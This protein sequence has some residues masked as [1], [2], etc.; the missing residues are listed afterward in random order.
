MR[1]EEGR[2]EKGEGGGDVRRE[3]EEGRCEKGEGGGDV[4]RER[5]KRREP[6]RTL[7]QMLC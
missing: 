1:R 5:E 6:T 4:R 3:R 7:G 2:Y